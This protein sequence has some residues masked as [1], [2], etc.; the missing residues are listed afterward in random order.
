MASAGMQGRSVK[1]G[2]ADRSLF[3]VFALDRLLGGRKYGAGEGKAGE[4]VEQSVPEFRLLP[5]GA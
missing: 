4:G 3:R 1:Q 5:W 2:S